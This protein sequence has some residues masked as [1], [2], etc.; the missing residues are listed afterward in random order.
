MAGVL[1]ALRSEEAQVGAPA[2]AA[3][4]AAS[5]GATFINPV[6]GTAVST[7]APKHVENFDGENYYFCCDGCWLEFRKDPARYAAIHHAA[8]RPGTP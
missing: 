6:C 5:A 4:R 3:S 2:A 7:S 1:A 8:A